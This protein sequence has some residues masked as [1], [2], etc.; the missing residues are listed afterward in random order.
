MHPASLGIAVVF[1]IDKI[2][3][4]VGNNHRNHARNADDLYIYI[5][6]G[7]SKIKAKYI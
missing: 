3:P 4:L 7:E 5:H 6:E 1:G 2:V